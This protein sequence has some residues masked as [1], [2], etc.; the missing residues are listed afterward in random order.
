MFVILFDK[1]FHSLMVY[2]KMSSEKLSVWHG[3]VYISVRHQFEP[4]SDVKKRF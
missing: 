3:L 1:L 4:I 2:G